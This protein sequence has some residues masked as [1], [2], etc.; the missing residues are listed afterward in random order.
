MID[1]DERRA[2]RLL[3]CRELLEA[4][5]ESVRIREQVEGL[6][7]AMTNQPG[8]A[9]SFCRTIIETTCKTILMD[10]GATVDSAWE[11][12]KLLKEALKYF[13]LGQT[14]AGPTD[15]RLTDS[16]E[17]LIRGLNSL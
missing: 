5:P 6:E 2:F 17:K 3:A 8:I 10:R 4:H 13:D 14:G 7:A 12:P 9:V 16:V 1:G 11:G 15:P